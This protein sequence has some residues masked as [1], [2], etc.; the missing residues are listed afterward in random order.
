MKIGDLNYCRA[1]A[2]AIGALALAAGPAALAQDARRTGEDEPAASTDDTL[3]VGTVYVTAR[4]REETAQ[5]VPVAITTIAPD[6]LRAEAAITIEDVQG[7]APNVVIDPVNAGPGGA[8]I[9]IRG[10]SFEDIEKSFEPTVGVVIDGVFLGTN[11]GQLLNTFDFE[12][13]EVLRGPQGTLFGRNTIGG[14][15]NIR[16]SRPTGTFGVRTQAEIGEYGRRDFGVVANAPLGDSLALK[17]FYFDRAFDGYYTNVVTDNSEGDNE[18]KNYGVTLAFEPADS[19]NLLLTV[20]AQDYGGGPAT[21]PLSSSAT[22]L[23]CSG[24]PGVLPPLS[25]A[26]ECNRK[27]GGFDVFNNDDNFFDLDEFDVTGEINWS[28][29]NYTITSI[30]AYRDFEELT[31]Q[32]FDS[33]SADFFDTSRA[34]VYDQFSQELR[35]AGPAGDRIGFVAG[36]YYFQSSYA[37]NQKTNSPLF[38]TAPPRTPFASPG[39]L[40]AQASQE[41]SSVAAFADIDVNLTDRLRLNLGGRYT[42]DEK[43][44][45]IA[46]QIFFSAVGATVPLFATNRLDASFD[47]FTPRVGLD[48]RASEN[49][50]IYGSWSQGFRAGGFNGRAGSPTSAAAIYRPETVD[51]FEIGFKSDLFDERLRLNVAAFYT[52]YQ[53]KQEEIVQPVP[54]A[55]QETRVVNAADAV[56][57][58]LEAESLLVVTENLR[59]TGSFGFLD[60]EYDEF[61]NNG[62]DFSTLELRRSP[63]TTF[64]VGANYSRPVGAGELLATVSFRR[65]G[66]YQTTITPAR[67]VFPIVNDPRGRSESEEVLNASIGYA[68]NVRN[69]KVRLSAFGRNITDDRGLSAALPVAGLFT[70]GTSDAPSVWGVSLGAEF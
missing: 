25:P 70:F 41:S 59:L 61:I 32:D 64:S 34:Q 10:L 19:L 30:S 28:V 23:I 22:D 53:D 31:L 68:F 42:R 46:N 47:K 51:S 39:Q 2:V 65:V 4:K 60:A 50:M 21:I 36:L 18:Y 26:N 24:I 1:V 54:G 69:A 57:S 8:A 58:G 43:D 12:Q 56:V 63:D 66:E 33:S 38:A 7:L 35:I 15:I 6:Q 62:V 17:A 14:V 3:R 20:E 67:G 27:S 11:T 52:S 49:L 9:S 44:F 5:S 55:G 16:R 40:R 45:Q 13:V 48:Y 29:G 37:L